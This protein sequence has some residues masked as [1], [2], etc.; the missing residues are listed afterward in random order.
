MIDPNVDLVALSQRKIK[1]AL[2]GIDKDAQLQSLIDPDVYFKRNSINLLISRR[3]VGKTYTVMTE[4]IKLSQLPDNS[5]Y[6]QFIY[7][8]DK[9]NDSTVNELIKLINLKTRVV[10]YKDAFEV[11]KD[12]MEAKMAYEQIIFKN[13]QNKTTDESKMDILKTLDMDDFIDYIPNTAILMDDAINILK[14]NKYK[15][16]VNLIFQNRQPRFTF[17]ICIQDTFSIPTCIRRNLD[18]VWIFAGMTDR[19]AFGMMLKQFGIT[20]PSANVWEFYTNNL[21]AHD[22]MI[23]DYEPDGIKLRFVIKG[24][25]I[26]L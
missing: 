2:K 11:L 4:L 24:R 7:I 8:S 23:F 18:T 3:G 16:L 15:K 13:L 14:E 5:G 9:T 17:F 6:T 21:G 26:E 19:L 10:K 22:A 12:I 1:K 20:I 25:K